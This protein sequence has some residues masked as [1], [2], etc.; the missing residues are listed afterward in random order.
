MANHVKYETQKIITLNAAID[1]F[2]SACK[3]RN[4]SGNTSVYYTNRLRAFRT[5]LEGDVK[6]AEITAERIR[7]FLAFECERNSSST[8]AHS[9]TA[10]S[11]FFNHCVA[12]GL[13]EA[14]PMANV[15][16]PKRKVC[17]IPTM[18]MEQVEAMLRTCGKDFI[19]VRDRAIILTLIDTGLRASE[20]VNL[21]LDDVDL[22]GQTMLVFGKGAKE[23]IVPFGSVTK[24]ALVGY[25]ARRGELETK[26]LF[27][28]CYGEPMTRNG[29]RL[30]LRDRGK[31]AGITGVRLSPHTLR[32]SMAVQYIRNGGDTFSLQKLLGHS[33]LDMT[34]RYAELADSDVIEKHRTC[35]PADR[36]SSSVK[37]TGRRRLV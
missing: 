4:L 32:H 29:L 22:A 5:F 16:K 15:K 31:A 23:R 11:A 24:Q 18:S 7:A 2:L 6:L 25:I 26:K 1:G 35:S 19:G 20:L 37:K 34:R 28:N 36:L 14:N 10:L 30:A 3:A 12:E 9:F 8:A 27:V 13:L 33:T 21:E 17:V